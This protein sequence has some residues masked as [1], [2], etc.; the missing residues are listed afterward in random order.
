VVVFEG[1]KAEW[2]CSLARYGL[3]RSSP[4]V[5]FGG[6]PATRRSLKKYVDG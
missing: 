1:T 4:A 3:N 5:F 2:E 6:I